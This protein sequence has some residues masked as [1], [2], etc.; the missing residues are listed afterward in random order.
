MNANTVYEVF[1]ALTPDEKEKFIALIN[2]QK[3]KASLN[4]KKKKSKRAVFTKQDAI[5]YL[6]ATVFKPK[7]RP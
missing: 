3:L 2:E 5:E 1:L 6:L 4:I 7:N